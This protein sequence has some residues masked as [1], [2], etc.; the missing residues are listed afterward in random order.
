[1]Y[2]HLGKSAVVRRQDI[3]GIFDLDNTTSSTRT[4]KFLERAEQE[5]RLVSAT[6][7][8]PKS[9]VVCQ[10]KN[11]GAVVYLSQLSPATLRGRM[12][13]REFHELEGE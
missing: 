10:E 5:G 2:L 13:S 4:R 6:D 3:I 12:E 11:G 9:F 7:D 1:M 8:L